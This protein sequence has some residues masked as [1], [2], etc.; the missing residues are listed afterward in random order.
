MNDILNN[1]QSQFNDLVEHVVPKLP[2]Y[3]YTSLSTLKSILR[4][5][6]FWF[7][8]YLYLND[9]MELILANNIILKAITEFMENS[10]YKNVF[11]E[12]FL[13]KYPALLNLSS[14]YT[15]SF[16]SKQDYLPAWRW[17]GDNGAGCSI[18]FHQDYFKESPVIGND[19]QIPKIISIKINYDAKSFSEI[20]KNHLS[21]IDKELTHMLEKNCSEDPVIDYG[22]VNDLAQVLGGNLLSLMPGFKDQ[23]YESENEYRLYQTE[24][25]IEEK[26]YPHEIP[27]K[28][29]SEKQKITSQQ[30]SCLKMDYISNQSETPRAKSPVFSHEDICEIWIGPRLDFKCAQTEIGNILKDAGY[31][32]NKVIISESQS[33]YRG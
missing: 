15:F 20:I 30:I 11:W 2:I 5:R 17:Y 32:E 31:D 28:F 27:N 7:T 1:L 23:G 3:H 18:G 16:C 12:N 19:Y 10:K 4:K 21:I 6:Q 24:L 8:D 26:Y 13:K 22:F 25:K 29:S 33:P 14:V 9:P